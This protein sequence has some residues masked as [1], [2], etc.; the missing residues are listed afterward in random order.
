MRS[1]QVSYAEFAQSPCPW[2]ADQTFWEQ[3]AAAVA[4]VMELV[5]QDSP[6]VADVVRFNP[7]AP[8]SDERRRA[9]WK[10]L[11]GGQHGRLE[12]DPDK[13]D[14]PPEHESGYARHLDVIHHGPHPLTRPVPLRTDIEYHQA[15]LLAGRAAEDYAHLQIVFGAENGGENVREIIG[16]TGQ[17]LR[18]I[19]GDLAESS[20]DE[21]LIAVGKL[22]G[23]D[24][25]ELMARSPFVQAE[26]RRRGEE[27]LA[28]FGTEYHIFRLVGEAAAYDLIDWTNYADAVEI[29]P[30]LGPNNELPYTHNGRASVVPSR[31]EGMAT[32]HLNDGRKL[33]VVNAPAIS[34]PQKGVP[35]ETSESAAVE[36]LRHVDV[37]DDARLVAITKAPYFRAGMDIALVYL[38]L[39]R[40]KIARFDIAAG[41]WD[42]A[43]TAQITALG[44]LMAGRKAD[45]RLRT[46][47]RG[48]DPF[49][50]DL[51]ASL[52]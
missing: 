12:T 2:V 29:A 44:E 40:G 14:I 7:L 41:A 46:A 15:E 26:L 33:H 16:Q 36:T 38:A 35:R 18:G 42:H 1:M 37:P 28:P 25:D 17:R 21:L 24:M 30:P 43:S 10:L 45:Y 3:N 50:P 34:R 22:T 6:Q 48:G 52:S 51:V 39:R 4:G 31:E 20:P 49:D 9:L 11:M 47:L 27:W 19:W 8:L 13:F 5:A 23:T 32:Y